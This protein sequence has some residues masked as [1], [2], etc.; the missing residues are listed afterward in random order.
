MLMFVLGGFLYYLLQIFFIK[1]PEFDQIEY[2]LEGLSGPFSLYDVYEFAR[3][4]IERFYGLL[5][6]ELGAKL[7]AGIYSAVLLF[8]TK[9]NPIPDHYS[10][11]IFIIG[12]AMVL[13][14]VINKDGSSLKEK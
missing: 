4:C 5:P 3:H 12:I 11:S 10:G 9:C 8:Y 14:N 2:G 6:V 13:L 7:L 1:A